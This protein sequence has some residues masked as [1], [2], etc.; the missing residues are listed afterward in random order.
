MS[1]KLE[2]YKKYLLSQ[3]KQRLIVRGITGEAL[4]L[5]LRELNKALGQECLEIPV[6]LTMK[7]MK[8][9]LE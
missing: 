8:Q 9:F 7:K 3:D 4:E 6:G 1:K 5:K 2:L